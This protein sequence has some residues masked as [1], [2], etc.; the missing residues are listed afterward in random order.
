MTERLT[1]IALFEALKEEILD[2]TTGRIRFKQLAH[3]IT[4]ATASYKISRD[5]AKKLAD[6]M[7][8]RLNQL[9]RVA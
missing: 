2:S 3:L 6:L 4:D 5:Q 8:E 9:N 1:G 7:E